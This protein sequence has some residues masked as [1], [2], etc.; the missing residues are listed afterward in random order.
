MSMVGSDPH[1]LAFGPEHRCSV[2]DAV[3]VPYLYRVILE[4]PERVG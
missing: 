3:V 4:T 1:V 2:D